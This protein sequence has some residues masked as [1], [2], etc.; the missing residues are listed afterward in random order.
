MH[1]I[2]VA[3]R[4][5]SAVAR[6]G[7]L[8]MEELRHLDEV[9]FVRFASVYR[10]FQDVD[11]FREEIE[12]LRKHPR[13]RK[14]ARDRGRRSASS[15]RCCREPTP[16]ERSECAALT[17]CHA[18]SIAARMA[19]GA[20]ARR[21]AGVETTHPNP[22]VGCVLARDGQDHRRRLARAGR[23][24]ARRSRRAA[25][26]RPVQPSRGRHRLRDARALQP[27]RPHAAVRRCADRGA[28][29]ARR[30]R[31]ATIRIRRV[32]GR[33]AEALAQGGHRTSRWG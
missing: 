18:I 2:R 12:K 24:A 28:R 27:S 19:R 17:E 6:V 29:G 8:V 32:S 30:V 23:R 7:E 11:A 4:A 25:Q 22:R 33:G 14:P 3:R 13:R 5:R 20:G 1:K 21:A 10:H 31:D 15:C 16:D 9:A 26:R